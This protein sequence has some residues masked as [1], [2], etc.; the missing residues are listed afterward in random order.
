MDGRE[1]KPWTGGRGNVHAALLL[2]FYLFFGSSGFTS[3]S[4]LSSPTSARASGALD[5]C[6][7]KRKQETAGPQGAASL[8]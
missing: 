8:G 3:Y 7:Q 4:S 6:A 5:Q 2:V 1:G